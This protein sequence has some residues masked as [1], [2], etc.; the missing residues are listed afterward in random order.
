[1]SCPICIS[2]YNKSTCA[3]ITCMCDYSA[4]KTC[5]RTY[6]LT[7]TLEPHC[8]NCRNKWSL[9]FTKGALGASFVNGD[10][11]EHQR[12][13]MLDSV[14]AKREERMQGAVNYR[15]DRNDRE[16][17]RE[18]RKRADEIKKELN[19]VLDQIEDYEN[20]I[21]V[22]N[23]RGR[24]Y[25]TH[26]RYMAARDAANAEANAEANVEANAVEPGATAAGATTT[27][28][29]QFVMP[30][31]VENCNGMLNQQY[32]CALCNT[33]TCSKCFEPE[34]EDH[35]CNPDTVATAKM[36]RKESKP[37]PKCGIRISK[38]DGCDQMWCVECK[39]A[40]SWATGEIETRHIHNP[41]Y[42]QFLREQGGEVPRNPNDI[43]QRG[44]RY[45]N[46]RDDAF[47]ILNQKRQGVRQP[48]PALNNEQKQ[49]LKEIMDYIE[50]ANH[51]TFS[52][53]RQHEDRIRTKT[54]NQE[55]EYL[56]I[57]GDIDRETLGNRVMLG[58][59]AVVKDQAFLDIYSAIGLMT[60]QICDDIIR[61]R[62][63][64]INEKHRTV[65]KW[66]AYFN[67]EL[68]KALM[69]H[70]SK[71]EIEVFYNWTKQIVK[72]ENKNKMI[73]ESNNFKNIYESA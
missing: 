49:L 10:L 55:N 22:R 66:S 46:D 56:Y 53:V 51:I 65:R 37:C 50:Y 2:N 31:Q 15:D 63:F 26:A 71:R 28:R 4:C 70:D 3:Q 12:K 36:L 52:V 44:C 42:F 40:F 68:V 24:H 48:G 7:T 25:R 35:E 1:M 57:L 39:T 21:N 61:N 20:A 41:H 64:D 45:R 17:I 67:M 5:I 73:E 62:N 72:Y 14:I 27:A 19:V 8:M 34:Q 43:V 33:K 6:L 47:R 11:K 58:H 59:R 9:E 29:R 13:V 69:L 32:M 23:G 18:L 38:I 16:T 60:D 54:N 30:C